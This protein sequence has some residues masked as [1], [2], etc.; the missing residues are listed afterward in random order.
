YELAAGGRGSRRRASKRIHE[1]SELGCFISFVLA[2]PDRLDSLIVHF[3]IFRQ[4]VADYFCPG[5]GQHPRL[6]SIALGFGGGDNRKTKR[7]LFQK[8]SC[9]I[10]FFL[11]P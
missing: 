1:D 5:R 8:P 6:F 7:I 4:I 2:K 10:E 11:V 9:F 3:E